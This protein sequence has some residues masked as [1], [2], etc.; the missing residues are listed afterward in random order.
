M[1]N[2]STSERDIPTLRSFVA[3]LL[4]LSREILQS[5]I[6][7]NE[8]DHLAFM[9]LCFV[10][11][12][13]EHLT[14]IEILVEAGQHK[15][16]GLIARSMI[17]GMCLLLWAARDTSTRPFLW[18]SYALVQDFR[19]M[20]AK[21]KAGERIDP[22]RKSAIMEQIKIHGP[23]FFTKKVQKTKLEG[24]P[25]PKDPY[26]KDTNWSG[27][28][29]R[30]ICEEVQ[31][32]PL[33]ERIYRETCQ[34]IHWTPRGLGSTIR[35]EGDMVYYLNQSADTA[36]TALASGFQALFESLVL[37]DSHLRLGFADRLKELGD[38]YIETLATTAKDEANFG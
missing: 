34:W 18:R 17:E 8:S 5:P 7:Y 10:S 28:N 31:G 24:L 26:R 14:T 30:E 13:I 12:Q 27:K 29:V 20:R 32:A 1:N 19:L 36:A 33:Y 23:Q 21:E 22:S 4:S 9:S 37:L 25:L 11:A 2:S 3:R 6:R 15:D 16:A 38:T 35:R